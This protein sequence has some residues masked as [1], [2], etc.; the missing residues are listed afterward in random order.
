[1]NTMAPTLSRPAGLQ[2]CR[3]RLATGPAA[4]AQ[5]RSQVRA[6]VCAWDVP[7]DAETGR[8]LLLAA[9]LSAEWG[10]Y[11]TPAGKV[12]YFTLACQP[13]VPEPRQPASAAGSP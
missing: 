1:M 6:V 10:C 8:G 5:A 12:V 11:R 4:A 13:G 9:T 7:V 2:A 3:V